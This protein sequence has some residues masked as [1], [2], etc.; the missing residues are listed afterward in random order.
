MKCPK[1]GAD[2]P[3]GS[4]YCEQCGEDIHIVPDFEPEVEFNIEQT[5]NG[6]VEE[7]SEST[8][9]PLPDE[10]ESIPEDD[11]DH[12]F[13]EK[14]VGIPTLI[15]ICLLAAMV[16]C[17]GFLI[18]QNNS[19]TYQVQKATKALAN[20]QYEKSI[21]A[22]SRALELEDNDV[23]ILFS[24]AEVYF[25]MND[26]VEYEKLLTEITQDE[27]AT[28]EQ[29]ERAWGK[30]IA[31]Y[32]AQ[33]DYQT[34]SDMLLASN[35]DKIIQS[36]QSYVAK[37]PEFS[38]QE[39]YYTSIQPLKL[40]AFGSGKIYYTLDGSIPNKS[41][42][43]YTAPIILEA[44]D[45]WVTAYYVNDYGVASN[46]V[47]K[48]Y[49]IEIDTIAAPEINLIGGEYNYPMNIEVVGDSEDVYYTTD[50]TTPSYSSNVYKGPIPMPIG[51]S[52]FQFAKIENGV[53]GE[54]TT[55]SYNL[56][57]KAKYT[58]QQAIDKVVQ[59]AIRIE[60]IFDE[61]GFI[62]ESGTKYI[63]EYQYV[64]NIN[65]VDD[66]YVCAEIYQDADGN[67]TKTGSYFAVNIYN[68]ELYKLH[69]DEQKNYTLEEIE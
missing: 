55:K 32:K 61:G 15:G 51:Q 56:V 46:P 57:L 28:F 64:T 25:Q 6:I 43:P 69:I 54:V 21:E 45:Y 39:G 8:E 3:N 63:Y 20:A 9:A 47:R 19:V 26:K 31:I 37:E 10:Q 53:V 22:F 35:N 13:K 5:L 23:E 38:I 12:E 41:S 67:T 60:K 2:I 34:I 36:F 44:G 66:F 11:W 7:I 40:T 65:E 62:D 49:H 58:P 68:G 27:R 1:C 30:L 50:G 4:L 48:E 18:Y 59:Y 24:L 17:V 16:L 14:R 29:L 52:T 33:E 42:E